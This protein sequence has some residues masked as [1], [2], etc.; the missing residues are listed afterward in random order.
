VQSNID[1]EINTAL[2]W[3]WAFLKLDVDSNSNL[4]ACLLRNLVEKFWVGIE[5][6]QLILVLF[7]DHSRILEFIPTASKFQDGLKS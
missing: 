6:G 2:E 4:M 7:G 5:I 3:F 1:T